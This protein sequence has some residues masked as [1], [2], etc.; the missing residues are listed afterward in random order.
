MNGIIFNSLRLKG[1]KGFEEEV[2]FN[3]G[4][5]LNPFKADN[6]QGKTSIGEGIVWVAI[7][8]NLNGNSRNIEVKNDK[9][10]GAYGELKFEL[11]G[12]SHTITRK[13]T[14]SVTIKLNDKEISQS[15]LNELIHG[16]IFL[17]LF[18]PTYFSSLEMAAQRKTI[19]DIMP[20]FGKDIIL[21]NMNNTHANVLENESF[22]ENDT[23]YY[24]KNRTAEVDKFEKEME[25][26]KGRMDFLQ[27]PIQEVAA[28]T[29]NKDELVKQIDQKEAELQA[30]EGQLAGMRN[31]V[32]H[33]EMLKS[34]QQ[35]LVMQEQMV[36]PQEGELQGIASEHKRITA[37][38]ARI[39]NDTFRPEQNVI[40][41]Q[42]KYVRK[43]YEEL[44]ASYNQ[45]VQLIQQNSQPIQTT[46]PTCSGQLPGQKIV[47]LQN[48]QDQRIAQLNNHL[49]QI[50]AEHTD[51][52]HQGNQLSEQLKQFNEQ[53]QKNFEQFEAGK[54]NAI[55][56]L[57]VE[58]QTITANGIQL[59]EQRT[60]FNAQKERVIFELKEK[61]RMAQLPSNVGQQV[62]SL[63]LKATALK[64][65]IQQLNA[66]I[67]EVYGMH[68][69]YEAYMKQ[70][71]ERKKEL[72]SSQNLF[73]EASKRSNQATMAIQ[74]MKEYN[75]TF[76]RLLNGELEK[77]LNK[78]SIVL[79]KFVQSTGEIKDA[80]EIQYEGKKLSICSTAENIKAGLEITN[81]LSALLEFKMPVFLDNAESI[82]AYKANAEQIIEVRVVKNAKLR[83]SKKNPLV[84]SL[85]QEN[86]KVSGESSA[87]VTEVVGSLKN[88]HVDPPI[89]VENK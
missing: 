40:E 86:E 2:V 76:V 82:T 13:Q 60:L 50:R 79:Q 3:F 56:Q 6:G 8:K 29:V 24:I 44:S 53:Q 46:C 70:L 15:E 47:E 85:V 81:M 69:A 45:Q 84:Q 30:I 89:A 35:Q 17:L 66:Q 72:A 19:V 9:S 42:L 80:F 11:N 20:T 62:E 52:Y 68:S 83:D 37:E 87:K 57:N 36:F 34:L 7:G 59:K 28:P 63:T 22:D 12:V 61:I 32:A 88:E 27:E 21:S 43:R 51:C 78:V 10:E 74:A 26:L 54:A 23:Q 75:A 14:S 67:R 65:E 39:K 49:E 64:N 4:P 48:Q 33:N 73:E 1:F 25:Q 5:G 31:E 58:L 41:N 18:N 55:Q 77:Y 16:D 71:D 38:I